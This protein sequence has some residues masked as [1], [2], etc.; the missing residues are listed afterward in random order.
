[1]ASVEHGGNKDNSTRQHWPKVVTGEA[2]AVFRALAR[3]VDEGR[4][5]GPVKVTEDD[6]YRY[7]TGLY[8]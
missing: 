6:G 2:A 3:L 7:V 1:M 8:R 4:A 5:V